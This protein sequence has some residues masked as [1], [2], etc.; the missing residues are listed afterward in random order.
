M[1]DIDLYDS[2]NDAFFIGSSTYTIKNLVLKN[3]NIYGAGRYGIYYYNPRGN[4]IY[5]N[6]AYENIGTANT[7]TKPSSFN[8]VENC[9][10]LDVENTVFPEVNWLCRVV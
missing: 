10:E 4:G 3:V 2:K 7:N 1:T 8:F 5:C 6:L 9:G